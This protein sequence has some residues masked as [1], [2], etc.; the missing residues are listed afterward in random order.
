VL[1]HRRVVREVAVAPLRLYRMTLSPLLPRS[2][3]F[4]PTCS[5]YAIEAVVRHGLA[6]GAWL[7]ARRVLRCRPACAAGLDPVP[8]ETSG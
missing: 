2:C 3:R 8:G 1:T 5:A 6:R 4:E 7:A